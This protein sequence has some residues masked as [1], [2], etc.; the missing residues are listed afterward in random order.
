MLRAL[1]LAAALGAPA[2]AQGPTQAA[3]DRVLGGYTVR[4]R[5]GPVVTPLPPDVAEF[6]LDHPD[7]SADLVRAHKLA[8][9]RIE[10]RGP[11]QSW[12]DDGEGTKG[13]ITL[14]RRSSAE[15]LY[16]GDGTH[17][18]ALLPTIRATAVI[19]MGVKPLPREGC[20]GS[21]ETSFEVYVR[22]KNPVLAGVVKTLRPLLSRTIVRKFGK[23]FLVADQVGRLMARDP[24]RLAAEAAESPRLSAAERARLVELLRP[25]RCG[26]S[27][28]F[29]GG[30]VQ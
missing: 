5:L 9:Y 14:V 30:G 1:A 15:R 26:R 16:Y 6:L 19:V 12:A 4:S 21:V 3:V 2:L 29:S 8:P 7:L 13:T 27:A 10:M 11:D 28:S 24:D 25:L 20:A 18:A 23:A 22:L 17:D